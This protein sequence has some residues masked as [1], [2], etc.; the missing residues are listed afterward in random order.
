[1]TTVRADGGG[2]L[3]E[4]AAYR[5]EVAAS[6]LVARLVSLDGET[7]LELR[8]L[9]AVDTAGAP[10]ETLSVEG[11][12]LVSEEP[13][14]IEVRR[15]STVWD[16]AL[17]RIV[18]RED[19]VELQTAVRGE[20]SLDVVR[21]LAF[22]SLLPG[23]P[24][25]LMPSGSRLRALFSPNPDDPRRFFRP[26]S[27]PAA[28]GVVGDSEPGRGRW[29]FTP[30]PLFLGLSRDGEAP[31]L[32]L[33]VVAPVEELAF[34]ELRYEPL[35]RAFCLALEYEGHTHVDGELALPALVLA[36]GFVDPYDALRAH[37]DVLVEAGAAPPPAPRGRPAW[38]S[39]PIFCGWG[40]QCALAADAG[41]PAA[42]LATRDSYDRFLAALARQELVPGIVVID[43]KWQETYG[44]N[45]PDTA[46]WP[47]LRGWIAGRHEAGQHVL[48]WWK[49]W[50]AEGLPPELCVR[51]PDGE[52]LGLDPSNPSAR[53]RLREV[54][55]GLLAPAGLDADGLKI[56]FTA[57][58]PSGRAAAAAGPGWGIA[59]LHELLAVVHA[60]AKEAKPDALVVTHTPHPAFVDV[61]DM[62]RLNDMIRLEDPDAPPSVLPQMRHRAAVVRAACPEL[63]VDTDD[64]C[65]PSLA[66]WREYLAEK[67]SL[68]IP[69]LYYAESLDATNEALAPDDYRALR[70]TWAAWRS[71][72]GDGPAR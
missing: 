18:C 20:G 63:L 26:A 58:T 44:A 14:T 64:W 36:P 33:G 10:D 29:F 70:E 54:V 34:P 25:G 11:P 38:W 28:I 5:L 37:R 45:E 31:W 60:A 66:A 30:A 59:L 39:E 9:A 24:N 41:V 17:T 68:G 55:H 53:A 40:A 23:A 6:G 62:I 8:P 35:D 69:A 21:L 27:E 22:R 67:T 72:Q 19:A 13:P 51:N 52:P 65:V 42:A 3:V 4:T 2:I 12:A 46:K 7:L 71:T 50:D 49:A 48:L 1:M 32:G 56:D 15:R 57:R 61:T 16:E 43:D 47:D